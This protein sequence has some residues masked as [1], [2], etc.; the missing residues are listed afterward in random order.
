MFKKHLTRLLSLI[1][2]VLV[3]VGFISGIGSATDKINYSMTDYYK[4]RN[5]SDFI[6]KSKSANGFTD[7]DF[8]TVCEIYGN[9][10]VNKGVSFD[11]TMTVDGE[12]QL[13]RLYFLDFDNITVNVPDTVETYNTADGAVTV[14]CDFPDNRLKGYGEGQIIELNFAE[15]VSELYTDIDSRYVEILGRLEPVKLSVGGIWQS[16]LTFAK[17]GEPSYNNPEDTEIPDDIGSLDNLITLDNIL[18]IPLDAIPKQSDLLAHLSIFEIL[19]LTSSGVVAGFDERAPIF[20]TTDLYIAYSDRNVFNAFDAGYK[21]LV[22]SQKNILSDALG[23]DIKV[24]SLYDNYSFLSLNSYGIKV[25]GIGVVLMVAFL[26][27]TALVVL[28]TMTRLMDEERS[29]VACLRTL[30][31]SSIKIISKYVFF[32]LIATG[33]GGVGAYFVG[34][35]LAYLIYQVFNYSFA[36]PPMSAH[37]AM[38]FFIITFAVIVVTTFAATMISGGKMTSEMP[39]TLLRP[40][41]PRAGKKVIF[42]R[43]PFFWNLLPFKYKSTTRN[44]LRYKSRFIMTVVAVAFSTA[45]VLAGLS[46]LD[47]CLFGG[48]ES[49][50]VMAIAIVVVVFAGLLT[51][52]VIYTLTNINI[53]ERNRELATLM[54][55][56][57]YDGEVAGYIYRE[58]YI[59][60]IVGIIFGYPLS[61]VLI[62]LVFSVMGMGTLGGMSWFMWLVA[63]VVVLLFTALVTLMLRRKIVRIDMNESLKAIE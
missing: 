46:I 35:G 50:S 1:F 36:M 40:K 14:Y 2:M 43:I 59:D 15:V 34:L 38:V 49:L 16:P 9:S 18:Y 57:Y 11:V 39:A 10:N 33:I 53:S 20:P 61:A 41:P 28:S 63:P 29:Q 30:G 21:S 52:V 12:E 45:L 24:L 22:N 7:E 54:V 4:A 55:L 17:D 37:V 8:A 3:S 48:L 23:E 60:T 13:T 51:M 27:V 25:A 31:Y 26:L 62:L 47:L 32:A 19:E 6:V 58:I 44:V 5:V 56:G 42:E